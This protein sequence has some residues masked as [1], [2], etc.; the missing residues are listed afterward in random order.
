MTG[1]KTRWVTEKKTR[2]VMSEGGIIGGRQKENK[3]DD[4]RKTTGMIREKQ[5][6]DRRK[7]RV[8]TRGE[9][10]VGDSGE[11]KVGDD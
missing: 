11:N 4:R 7:T 3:V 10:K 8:M 9:N 6:G 1:E 2:R 5:G